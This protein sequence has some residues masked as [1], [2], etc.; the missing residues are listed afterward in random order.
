MALAKADVPSFSG[1][2]KLTPEVQTLAR[3]AP[4]DLLQA[5]ATIQGNPE[6]QEV[7]RQYKAEMKSVDW[8]VDQLSV[9]LAANWGPRHFTEALEAARYLADEYAQI[10]EGIL[11][12]S[13]ET[14]KSIAK[15]TE[16]DLWQ[17][18]DVPRESGSMATPLKRIRPDLEGMIIL[19]HFETQREARVLDLLTQR[20]NQ[21]E[22]LQQE[23]DPRLLIATKKGRHQMVA[24]LQEETPQALLGMAGGTSGAF[25]SHFDLVTEAPAVSP[26]TP[27]LECTAIARSRM[28]IQD[29]Q[30]TN[31]NYN[32]RLV[33]R[34][35][36]A[37]GW[38]REVA[39]QFSMQARLELE[40]ETLHQSELSQTHQQEL[41]VAPPDT[42]VTLTR[43]LTN[44]TALPV[45]GAATIG[46][47]GKVGILVVKTAW[48]CRDHEMF[49]KWEVA[50]AITYQLLVDWSKVRLFDIAG[51]EHQGEVVR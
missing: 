15:L 44:V 38:V 10:G 16:S 14:G 27:L 42:V 48:D 22:L 18:P 6:I 1:L 49:Q 12:V 23:G 25:L 39:R 21:T 40:P 46:L 9:R 31:L 28:G 19:W 47:S 8:L 33:L 5:R 36:M 37:Q 20:A 51:I 17:P 50:G 26:L 11:I 4:V 41:W 29:L 13:Q 32:R 45:E 35:V 7:F 3:P 43:K 2:E 34:G 24:W 30:T